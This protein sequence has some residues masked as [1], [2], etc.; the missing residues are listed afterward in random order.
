MLSN[1]QKELAELVKNVLPTATNEVAAKNAKWY[2][3]WEAMIGKE[4]TQEMINKGLDRYQYNGVLY[5]VLQPHMVEE[6]WA[7]PDSPSLWA[8]VLI[9][10]PDVIPPWEPPSSTNPYVT[11]DKV[12]HGGKTWE[13]MVDNNVWEPGAIGTENLWKELD[14]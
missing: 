6:S 5:V 10:N 4:I 8:K 7:P 12:T 2:P 1:S 14:M 9:P 13:S 11:G 3:Q